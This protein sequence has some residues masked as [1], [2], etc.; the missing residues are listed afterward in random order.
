MTQTPIETRTVPTK[1]TDNRVHPLLEQ[2]TNDIATGELRSFSFLILQRKYQIGQS[3]AQLIRQAMLREGLAQMDDASIS[4]CKSSGVQYLSWQS[5]ESNIYLGSLWNP[6]FI[7]AVSGIQYLSWQSLESNIYLGSLWNPIFILAVSGVQYL[8]WQSLE[9]NIYLGSL[10]NPIFIL[11]V[12]GVQYLSWQSLESKIYL[13]S[14]WSPRFI[15]DIY[16]TTNPFIHLIRCT[17][18]YVTTNSFSSNISCTKRPPL[19]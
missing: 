8:S 14:L 5:L 9:S 6:I 19:Y 4:S 13:G 11:A 18:A 1:L 10:W 12:S 17:T 16:M 2:V 15:L 7:L 3:T